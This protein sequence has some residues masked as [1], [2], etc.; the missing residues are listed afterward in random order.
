VHRRR[1]SCLELTR[2]LM[3]ALRLVRLA[4]LRRASASATSQGCDV[5]ELG[6]LYQAQN[7]IREGR[8]LVST[9]ELRPFQ[10]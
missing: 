3:I 7:R 6:R 4:A 2:A 1:L 5:A 9:G 10:I 8:D